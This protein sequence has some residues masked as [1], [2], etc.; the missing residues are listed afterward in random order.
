MTKSTALKKLPTKQSQNHW[1][2]I[3]G[4]MTADSVYR[5]AKTGLSMEH[6]GDLY[7]CG[8]SNISQII[9]GDEEMKAAWHQGHTE[10]LVEL[11][12]HIRERMLAN[13]IFLMFMLKAVFG[14]CEE[15]HKLG[16]ELDK[17][18]MPKV[19]I[20]LPENGRNEVDIE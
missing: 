1:R 8:K 20:Y 3:H 13:D 17:N 14:Y 5:Y 19:M 6:I 7:G 12:P 9:S 11:M 10:L 4:V 16:K 15:Q 18:N 2:G